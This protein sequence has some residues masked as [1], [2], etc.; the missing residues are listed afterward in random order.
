MPLNSF[1]K[2]LCY[3]PREEEILLLVGIQ[4]KVKKKEAGKVVPGN[5]SPDGDQS[6][7]SIDD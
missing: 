6:L 2:L 7:E 5:Q 1:V 3:S 4:K